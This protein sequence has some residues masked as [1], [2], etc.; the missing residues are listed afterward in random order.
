MQQRG[1]R[2]VFRDIR[3]Y[4]A[5][6]AIGATRDDALLDE[7][8]KCL[9]VRKHMVLN[10]GL[11]DGQKSGAV[12]RSFRNYIKKLPP[13]PGLSRTIDLDDASIAEINRSLRH[14]PCQP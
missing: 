8:M 14:R 12:A 6:S 2:S 9:L 7:V 1:Q 13:L 5:G 10:G 3:D 4:L 11:P